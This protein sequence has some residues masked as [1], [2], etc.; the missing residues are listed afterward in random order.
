MQCVCSL[1]C[2]ILHNGTEIG[3]ITPERGLRQGDPLSP[4]LFIICADSLSSALKELQDKGLIHG[5]NIARSAPAISHL[6]FVNDSY[7]FFKACSKECSRVKE[8]LIQYERALEQRISLEKSTMAFSPNV[9]DN[10]KSEMCALLGMTNTG[11]AGKYLGVLA[12][13]ERNKKAIL[14]YIY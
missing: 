4:Y 1:R 2:K 11:L 12:I 13:I 10:T 6:F 5:C 8:C 14:G 3:P 7:F 9:S